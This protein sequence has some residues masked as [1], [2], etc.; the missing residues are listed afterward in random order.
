MLKRNRSL[1]EK[2][3]ALLSTLLKISFLRFY[4]HTKI[5]TLHS[6][7]NANFGGGTEGYCILA[8]CSEITFFDVLFLCQL[9][10]TIIISQTHEIYLPHIKDNC[11]HNTV[12]RICI[13]QHLRL[14]K[15]LFYIQK[16]VHIHVSFY[17][18]LVL[19]IFT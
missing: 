1:V 14:C 19:K 12:K 16:F 10:S 11:L 9:Q 7:L 13:N 5:L 18:H 15:A 17:Y 6:C 2:K 3:N 4:W 8:I